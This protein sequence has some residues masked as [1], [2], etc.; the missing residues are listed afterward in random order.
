MLGDSTGRG[1]SSTRKQRHHSHPAHQTVTRAL[2]PP[3]VLQPEQ[4][5]VTSPPLCEVTLSFLLQNHV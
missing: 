1:P 5:H 4:V 3:S 2:T